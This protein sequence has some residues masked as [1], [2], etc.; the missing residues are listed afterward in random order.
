MF[1]GRRENVKEQIK[2]T[3]AVKVARAFSFRLDKL[4]SFEQYSLKII[5]TEYIR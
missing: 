4:L 3:F 2:F 5:T 1:A